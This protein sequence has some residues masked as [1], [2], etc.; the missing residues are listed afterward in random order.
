MP[1]F[2][3]R[4]VEH[5]VRFLGII[6]VLLLSAAA[7]WR[8]AD[9]VE[10]S[11]WLRAASARYD[12]R[13]YGASGNGVTKDTKALQSAIDV[14]AH[15]G[16][17]VVIFPP[18]AYISGTIH[19]RSN[20]TLDLEGGATLVASRDD[21]DFDPYE[22][23]SNGSL[24]LG[25][26][27]WVVDKGR[28][29][30]AIRPAFLQRTAD[31]PDTTYTDY[32]LIVGDNVSNVAIDGLGTIEGNRIARGGPK[33][34]AL[35]NCNHVAIRGITLRDAPNYNISLVGSQNVDIEGLSILN[36]YADG[37]DP[38][39]SKFVRIANCYI[40]TW[41][42]AIC[43][44]ASLAMG[45]RMSTENLVV[46]NCILKTSNSAFK[47][48]T[49]SE[50]NLHN[51][52][53]NNCVM[54]PRD[55]GRPPISGV[56]IESVDGGEVDGVVV[57]NVVMREVR[58]PIFLRLGN[59]GRGMAIGRPGTMS[60]IN[61]SD[62]VAT[63]ATHPISIHGLPGSPIKDVELSNIK[64][65]E[66]GGRRSA[67][68]DVPE[69]PHDYPEGEMFGSLPAY[70]IYA[71]HVDGL[72]VSNLRADWEQSDV[73]PAAIFEDIK[74]LSVEDVRVD[75][76]SKSES[77]L[78]LREV[79]DSMIRDVS[80]ESPAPPIKIGAPNRNRKKLDLTNQHFALS[81]VQAIRQ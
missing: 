52:A 49:E 69:L 17:G 8:I 36:G 57:S 5:R 13:D 76:R 53:L 61:I 51:V 75:M 77:P 27:T 29:H 43:A 26:I 37:I 9:R 23:P 16:G 72:S 24:S 47:F 2:S 56:A 11:N 7:I 70:S 48:G 67:V 25:R 44:K 19:L 55:R 60:N 28:P 50:G 79:K 63:D 39:G 64:L 32:S 74:A 30:C 80:A 78:I 59:R 66:R 14:A 10:H 46:T 12:V 33:L 42:D 41:D 68:F 1:K 4:G 20:V 81:K 15:N 35:R 40:D 45:H 71:R 18:G 6:A 31:N 21:G 73:R 62:I 38:D 65:G 22:A 3:F 34:I 58:T 54:L